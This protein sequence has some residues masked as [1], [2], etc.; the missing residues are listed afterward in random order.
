MKHWSQTEK[1]FVRNNA[2]KLTIAQLAANIGRT[3]DAIK[4]FLHRNRIVIGPTVQRNIVIELLKLRFKNPEDFTPSKAFY[5]E[6]RLTAPRWWDLYFGRKSITENEYLALTAY[7]GITLQEA[8]DTRQL[9]FD[10]PSPSA[11][12]GK[13]KKT[14]N[15]V[16][17]L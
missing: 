15:H 11:G 3:E 6:T 16:N 12:E 13:R 17:K 10:F 2:G 8:F 4:L 5:A 9:S 7:F 14:K 1:Q